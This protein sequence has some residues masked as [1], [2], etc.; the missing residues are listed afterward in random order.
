ML[1]PKA[2]TAIARKLFGIIFAVVRDQSV[3]RKDFSRASSVIKE[4][5]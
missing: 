3:Y 5:A 1:K 4:A 2:L